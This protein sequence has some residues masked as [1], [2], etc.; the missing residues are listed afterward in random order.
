VQD[1]KGFR[2]VD[3]VGDGVVDYGGGRGVDECFD[4]AHHCCLIDEIL[5]SFHINLLVHRF[6]ILLLCG[7]AAV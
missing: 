5:G 2:G 7:A 4:G 6:G 3:E 1:G